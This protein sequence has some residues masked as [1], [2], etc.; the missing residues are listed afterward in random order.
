MTSETGVFW[1]PDDPDTKLPGHLAIAENG[2][3]T[4]ELH[5]AITPSM[6]VVDHNEKTGAY[7][8]EPA[9]DPADL[10]IHGF[11][12]SSP[13]QVTLVDCMTTRRSEVHFT[14]VPLDQHKLIANVMLRGAHVPGKSATFT[15]VRIR[16]GDID[17]WAGLGGFSREDPEDGGITV[18][19]R[20]V[21]L[22]SVTTSA[23][24]KLSI[25]EEIGASWG[26]LAE[27]RIVRSVW[28]QADSLGPLTL[29]EIDRSFA[30]PF[31]SYLS[32][33]LGADTPLTAM[34]VKHDE[35]WLEVRHSG[36]E[37]EPAR[38]VQRGDVLLP[39]HSAGLEILGSF[40][41]VYE[42]T[43]PAAPVIANL[44]PRGSNPNIETQVV[45][46]TTV[47]EGVHRALF[48]EDVRMSQD[49]AE[50][51]QALVA[52][53]VAQ[54]DGRLQQIVNG[55]VSRI[56]EASYKQ[57][58]KRLAEE[59]ATALPGVCGKQN[60]W[61]TSVYNARNSFAHR[62]QG[63]LEEASIEEFYAVSQSLRWVLLGIMLLKSGVSAETLA[64]RVQQ[65]QQYGLFLQ[66][67]RS[68]LP[69]VY[70]E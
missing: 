65:N 13:R 28:L 58:L 33:A 59:T 19:V 22:P 25:K 44:L 45:E 62:T 48:P 31:A 15:G 53:A 29:Q 54:E 6:K 63:F 32:F 7:T 60:R 30:S 52:A 18:N 70:G 51:L 40:L 38:P 50:R 10:V 56:E 16:V 27:S 9:D 49:E 46:L 4:L 66:H 26:S 20:R 23:G 39:L 61:V 67:M 12:E 37:G 11:L 42:K 5:G 1:L 68:S 55:S 64:A 36:I 3:P 14:R 35:D 34:Q 21:N 8:M 57:R 43:G 17:T 41:R 69:S 24:E 2:T 47:A